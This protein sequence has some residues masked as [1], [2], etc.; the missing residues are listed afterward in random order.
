M[1][2]DTTTGEWVPAPTFIDRLTGNVNPNLGPGPGG[3][4][5]PTG[6][7]PRKVAAQLLRNQFAD[8]EKSFKPIELQ[9][10]QGISFN[11][12]SILTDAVAKASSVASDQ[13]GTMKGIAERQN[14]AIGINPTSQQ[15]TV[16]DRTRNLSQA[17]NV[18]GAENTARAN[19]RSQDEQLLLGATP[20]P[21][22][23]R[24][25]M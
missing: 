22:I 13:S 18:A 23:V 7:D 1:P 19:V 6:G 24:G 20:N 2:Y 12:P 3:F 16:M 9:A 15:R 4:V 17:A 25:T 8:W 10:I 21:N 14:A 5:D 11:N